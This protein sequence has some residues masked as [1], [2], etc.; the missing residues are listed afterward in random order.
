M[1]LMSKPSESTRRI[2]FVDDDDDTCE[3]MRLLLQHSGYRVTTAETIV[4]A[5]GLA[6]AERFDLY[7]LDNWLPD[8]LGLELCQ[9]L[10]AL[11][12]ASP[13][14]FY[15]GIAQESEIQK[16]RAA[17]ADDYL[18]K[19]CD[20]ELLQNTIAEFLQKNLQLPIS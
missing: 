10:R 1:T 5:L 19:P 6:K 20:F 8:G 16:A 3:M 11:Y 13:I 9:Q 2:L 7:L 4:D 17:G 14:V 18:V 12:P 15:S